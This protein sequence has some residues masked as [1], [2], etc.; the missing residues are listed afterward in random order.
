LGGRVVMFKKFIYWK[1]Q[2]PLISVAFLFMLQHAIVLTWN[3]NRE[4][5]LAGY[6]IYYG[7][8]SRSYSYVIDV[9]LQN[10]YEFDNI[11]GGDEYFF[12]VTAYDK[13]G[14]E[15]F[16]SNEVA[17]DLSN[18][19]NQNLSATETCYNFPNP[20]NP[21]KEKTFIRFFLSQA[22]YV[23]INIYDVNGEHI[24][25]IIDKQYNS[26]GEHTDDSWDGRD[27]NGLYVQ[28]GIYYAV[29]QTDAQKY[30]IKIAVV[31]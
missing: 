26:I 14:N 12:A 6:K 23:T 15:S 29:I 30:Y 1:K 3:E 11:Q 13:F 17:I 10:K 21:R 25:T 24:R 7:T 20:F 2:F 4:E 19:A 18:L 9:G 8:E 31:L 22:A 5:D 16:F 28:N 27:A